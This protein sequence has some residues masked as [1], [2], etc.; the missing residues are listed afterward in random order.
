[1]KTTGNNT[2]AE[3]AGVNF[4]HTAVEPLRIQF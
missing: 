1:M 4:N 2:Y 3:A